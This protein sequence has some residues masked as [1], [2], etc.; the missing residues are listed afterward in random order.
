[1]T[2]NGEQFLCNDLPAQPW[3]DVGTVLVAGATGYIGGRLV[4][5][6]LNRGYRLRVMV[7][8]ESPEHRERWPDID[9]VVADALIGTK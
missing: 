2:T 9:V 1:M 6:L 8:A 3:S 7:R 5:E 4:P